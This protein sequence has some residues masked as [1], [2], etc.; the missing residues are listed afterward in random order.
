MALLGVALA[1]R[2]KTGKIYHEVQRNDEGV[3]APRKAGFD[4][5]QR[6]NNFIAL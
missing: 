6:L 4:L 3:C 2:I 1:A 5:W